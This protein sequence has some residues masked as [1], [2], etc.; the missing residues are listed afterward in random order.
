MARPVYISGKTNPIFS[1]N[2]VTHTHLNQ[3]AIAE[4]FK[5]IYTDSYEET[6][7]QLFLLPTFL[8]GVTR[9]CTKTWSKGEVD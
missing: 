7:V 5:T 1:S 8:E 2:S 3:K 4:G 9:S 6:T